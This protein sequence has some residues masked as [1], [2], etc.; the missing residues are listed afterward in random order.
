MGSRAVVVVCRDAGV[1]ARALR[2]R[3]AARPASIYTRTGRPFFDD[4]DAEAAARPRARRG[5]A[6][7]PVGRARHRLARARLR[8]DAVVGEGAG[9][10][11]A[12]VRRRRRGRAG[13]PDARRSRRSSGAAARGLRRQATRS[14]AQTP[15]PRARRPLR[16]RL[17]PLLLAGRTASPTC[18]SRRSTCSPPRAAS[19]SIATTPGTWTRC[20]RARRRPTRR[21]LQR[22]DRRV[23]DVTDADEP[24]RGRR[25]GGRS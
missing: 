13:R 25:R 7:R 15:A 1:A 14:S 5:R 4:A 18:G 21:W 9:A 8:A 20:D 3:R 11:P 6:R 17:P 12:P 16:R 23:V 10:D 24:G 19:T 22:T 2:R